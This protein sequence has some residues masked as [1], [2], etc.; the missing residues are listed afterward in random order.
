MKSTFAAAAALGLAVFS[1]GAQASVVMSISEVGSDVVAMASGTLNLGGLSFSSQDNGALNAFVFPSFA[2]V[3]VGPAPSDTDVYSGAIAGPT[4]FGI[5]ARTGASSGAGDAFALNGFTE[6]LF[7]P[8]DY[9]SGSS[10]SASA[11][12]AGATLA[13]LGISPGTYVYSW[14]SGLNADTFTIDVERGA[15]PEPSTWA[16][17]G[18]GF[19]AL[20]FVSYRARRSAVSIA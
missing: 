3:G 7:V 1:A 19:A 15:V 20:G 17:M 11:T 6:L 18:L 12:F 9:V 2:A 4:T 13:S 16:M 8:R 14:G 5:G 10:L